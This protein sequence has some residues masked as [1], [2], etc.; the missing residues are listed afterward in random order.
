LSV[1]F[2]FKIGIDGVFFTSKLNLD[3]N[4]FSYCYLLSFNANLY[5]EYFY[6][7]CGCGKITVEFALVLLL[8][9]DDLFY[10]SH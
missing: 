9:G 2:F 6:F 7:G 10:L 4:L 3:N 1:N 8:K 5:N